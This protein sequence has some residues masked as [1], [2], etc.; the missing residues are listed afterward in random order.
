LARRRRSC[1]WAADAGYEPASIKIPP[2]LPEHTARLHDSSAMSFY[3]AVV[4]AV[5][6]NSATV[7]IEATGKRIIL[8]H[9]AHNAVPM[10]SRNVGTKGYI[11]FPKAPPVFT[12]ESQAA[13]SQVAA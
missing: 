5:D 4:V 9:N 1:T 7:Q 12:P 11:S 10:E 13:V 3:P 2:R 6:S 8:A